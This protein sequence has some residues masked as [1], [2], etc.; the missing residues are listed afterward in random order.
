MLEAFCKLLHGIANADDG[1]ETVLNQRA[2]EGLI[3]LTKAVYGEHA[4]DVVSDHFVAK[5]HGITCPCEE[6]EDA[7]RL[8]LT[9]VG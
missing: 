2:Y 1:Q 8:T 6:L 3:E 9:G 4:A 5:K 7:F